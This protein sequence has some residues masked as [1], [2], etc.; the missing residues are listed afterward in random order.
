MESD[1]I[2]AMY[3]PQRTPACSTAGKD[4]IAA[5]EAGF[6]AFREFVDPAPVVF[7]QKESGVKIPGLLIMQRVSHPLFTHKCPIYLAL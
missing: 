2:S 6:D 5:V 1:P 4:R 3:P 7:F